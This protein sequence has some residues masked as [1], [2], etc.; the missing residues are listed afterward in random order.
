MLI[1]GLFL[2][3]FFLFISSVSVLSSVSNFLILIGYTCMNDFDIPIEIDIVLHVFAVF[4][5]L[6]NDV[7]FLPSSS[8]L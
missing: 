4:I 6:N 1:M 5:P 2:W 7:I 8:V 3:E